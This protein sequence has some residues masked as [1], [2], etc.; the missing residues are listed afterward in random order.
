MRLILPLPRPLLPPPAPSSPSSSAPHTTRP[1]PATP[2]PALHPAWVVLLVS[3]WLATVCN[4]PLWREV[5]ALPGQGSL[6]G[7]GFALAFGAIVTAGNAGLLALLAWRWTLKPAAVLLVLMAAFGAYFMLAYGIAIDASML[8]NVVQ[9]DVHE[10]GDLL[11]LRMLATVA[12][13]AAPP[14][15][16]LLRTPVRR[17]PPLRQAVHNGLLLL[18]AIAVIVGSLLAVFQDFSSTMRN[19]TKLRY[20][21][22]PLNSVYALGNV[23][24]KPLRMDQR[25]LV[26]VGRDAHLG[27][28]YAGQAKPPLLVLVL[29]ETGRSGNFGINGY[30]RDTTPLLSARAKELVSA[31]NAWSCG[32]STAAS[33]PCMF[34]HL[35][36]SGY[37]GRSANFE[38][39]V[40][41][42]HHAGLA[43]LWLDNQSGCKGVCDRLGDTNTANLKD[44]ALCAH[45]GECLDRIM[46]KDLDARIAALP[47]E[48][49]QRGTVV[50]MH[51]L[52]S[53]GPAYY[54]RSAPDAKKF[55]PE[56]TSTA[57]QECSRQQVVNAYDNSIVEID[58]FLDGVIQW[59][60]TQNAT[61]QTAMLYV[62]DHGESLGENNIYLHGL[63]Y[64]I[65]PDVQ[66]H[67]PWITWLSPAMQARV[68]AS[69]GCLQKDLRERRITHD[70]YFHSVLGLMDV[71]TGA[72]QP[73]QDM[74]TPCR[75]AGAAQ[76]KADG[77]V[78]APRKS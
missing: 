6:R 3:L 31:G 11:S 14:L 57:L 46:L 27:A 55:L 63:P 73:E 69:T 21:I 37:E 52:G 15:L 72:Y 67:V 61:A 9:T 22:N 5:A 8:T 58:R 59:L 16:W 32:T 33:V 20:L 50:V 45:Q 35:G 41:V 13:L 43:V 30:A 28:S 66:K 26:P 78:A 44:P 64:S 62:A 40:D 54:K 42:L 38:S 70:H 39:L 71:Q 10:A 65:A 36:K 74:F 53:H 25:T 29:G 60:G 77:P 23:A 18:A 48:Q 1:R 7:Y 2:P 76:A 34:S 12:A 47:A 4:V 19:H 56:C 17:L 24:T 75:D 68:G 51:Q 49:R